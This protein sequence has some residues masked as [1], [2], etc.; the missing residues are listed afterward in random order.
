MT[1]ARGTIADQAV[2]VKLH[3]RRLVK[4]FGD[5][6]VLKALDLDVSDGE[7]L[8]LLGPSGSGK[9]TLLRI[10]AGFENATSGEM[11]IGDTDLRSLTP[12]ERQLGMV[13]QNYALFPHMT[14]ADNVAY[15]LNVRKV[16]GPKRDRR[17]AEMLEIVGLEHL[18][19]R[20]PAQLSGGQQQRV[21]LARALAYEP[22]IL[23]MDEPLGALD[24]SLRLQMETEI[25]RVHRQIGT[26]VIYVTHDQEEAL[27]LSDRV[28]IMSQGNFAG[29]DTPMQLF[30]TPP[31]SFVAKFFSDSNI[32]D[33]ELSGG[34]LRAFSQ[35]AQVESALSGEVKLAARPALTRIGELPKGT[36]GFQLQGTVE[37]VNL[38]GENEQLELAIPGTGGV[39]V[40]R[41]LGSGSSVSLGETVPVHLAA[42]DITVMAD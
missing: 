40:R 29:L 24:R 38:L 23:L 6:E 15:G 14:V 31:N 16:R 3:I 7:F 27:V 10:I 19:D 41:A 22:E 4:N 32:F 35:A 9:T 25:K 37:E 36:P 20:R 28:A 5:T 34:V 18:R 39:V 11:R 8:T 12:S 30:R 21:A 13:F 2:D 33:G 1:A 26:T 42:A 17:V